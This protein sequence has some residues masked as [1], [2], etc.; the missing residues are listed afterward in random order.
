M[1]NSN[2]AAGK[3]MSSQ[4]QQPN[5]EAGSA[6]KRFEFLRNEKGTP[7]NSRLIP[8]LQLVINDYPQLNKGDFEKALAEKGVQKNVSKI[9]SNL[10]DKMKKNPE[11][12][13]KHALEAKRKLF[14][15]KRSKRRSV[16]IEEEFAY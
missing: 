2:P 11:L 5:P 10:L 13:T 12:Y 16:T 4:S 1:S 15:K 6:A 3:S 8:Q 9:V 7:S 14:P